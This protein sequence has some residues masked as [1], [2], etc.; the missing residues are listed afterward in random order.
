MG[1]INF[2]KTVRLQAGNVIISRWKLKAMKMRK[3]LFVHGSVRMFLISLTAV[4][5]TTN[6]VR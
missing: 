6:G 3:L 2:I 1:N 5:V 4:C